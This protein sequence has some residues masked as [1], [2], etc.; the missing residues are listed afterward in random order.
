MRVAISGAGLTGPTLAFWLHRFGHQ[1]TL[2]EA[3]PAPRAG[4][5]MIDFWGVGYD[6]AE[7]MGLRDAVHA[8]GYDLQ[9]VRYV[10]ARGRTVGRIG[11]EVM[12]RE[13]GDRFVSLS[14]GGLATTL[15]QAIEGRVEAL[16]GTTVLNV[17]PLEQRIR[18]S[19]S[20][21]AVRDFDVLVGADG[22][23]S[24]VR[25]LVFGPRA[26]YER[27][28]GYYVAAFDAGHY[29]PRD[30]L[31][32]VSYGDPGRQISRFSEREDRTMFLFVFASEHLPGAEPDTLA[33]KKACLNAVFRDVRW[34]WPGI[35]AALDAAGEIYFDRVSQIVMPAW[36]KGRV[37][38]VGDAAG[39]VSLVAGEGA[40]IGMSGA[41]VLAGELAQRDGDPAVAF[42]RYEARMRP[43]VEG[44]QASARKFA[45]SFTPRTALG[46]WLRNV[47]TYAM[48]IPGVPGLLVGPQ[49]R[50][51]LK[52]PD[53]DVPIREGLR[54]RRI[55]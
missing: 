37:V 25:D 34:E 24:N 38:L 9:E 27:Q 36:S 47:A 49:M 43:F 46:V 42:A 40:G 1:A 35:K 29:R 30:E 21:G 6:V 23:H 45:S 10:D 52:L 13:L 5:Y 41:Y 55:G 51:E 28:L 16:F 7:R 33:A 14:R 15:Y 53:D 32:Y 12:R 2:V 39:A 4:G 20:N 18:L 11:I 31:A 26:E 8:A 19:L 22:L 17:E 3:A 50:D 44:K 48:I 54:L